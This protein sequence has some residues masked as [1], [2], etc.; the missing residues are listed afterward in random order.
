ML[1]VPWLCTEQHYADLKSTTSTHN[2]KFIFGHF[3]TLRKDMEQICDA[4]DACVESPKVYSGHM[5]VPKETDK[6]TYVGSP[7][8]INYMRVEIPR[9]LWIL[10]T[11]TGMHSF[12]E[13]AQHNIHNFT[14]D[15]LEEKIDSLDT[16]NSIIHVSVCGDD[17]FM[18]ELTEIMDG[19]DLLHYKI[20]QVKV[21]EVKEKIV[22]EKPQTAKKTA[23]KKKAKKKYSYFD[24]RNVEEYRKRIEEHRRSMPIEKLSIIERMDYGL[25]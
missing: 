16:K 20:S 4:F 22:T 12:Y 15:E 23:K 1:F 11:E 9:G 6:I 19:L 13:Y 8:P 21:V 25:V 7:I 17:E 18:R 14:F 24:P 5:H 3:S 10:D 2:P